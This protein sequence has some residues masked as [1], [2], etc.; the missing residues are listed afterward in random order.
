M[1]SPSP[2]RRMGR[3]EARACRAYF[4][5][6]TDEQLGSTHETDTSVR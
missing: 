5:G 6:L 4:C 1:R 2:L 3:L